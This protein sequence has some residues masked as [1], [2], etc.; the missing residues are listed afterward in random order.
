MLDSPE[1]LYGTIDYE[2]VI[3]GWSVEEILALASGDIV[4]IEN[5]NK[6]AEFII[7][8]KMQAGEFYI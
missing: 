8:Q 4:A 1:D 3:D 7:Y 2:E 6:H 5:F